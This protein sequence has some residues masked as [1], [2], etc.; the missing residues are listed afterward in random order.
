MKNY[1]VKEAA[2]IFRRRPETI[3]E[4]I[5]KQTFQVV[6]KVK[7]GYLIPEREVNRVLEK[8]KFLPGE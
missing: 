5:K 2:E 6:F 7:D 8:S 4:W 1:T 3:R